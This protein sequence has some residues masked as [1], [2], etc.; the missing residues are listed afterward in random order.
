MDSA[1]VTIRTKR[2]EIVCDIELPTKLPTNILIGKIIS[3][4]Y[5]YDKKVLDYI[6]QNKLWVEE[7]DYYL[8]E[9]DTLS[10]SNLW[11]GS[12]ITIC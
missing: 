1:I 10:D 9:N 2:N 11:D 7:R 6:Q 12:I 4:L 3:I 8:K 5:D